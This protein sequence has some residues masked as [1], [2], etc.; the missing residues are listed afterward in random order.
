LSADLLDDTVG[1]AKANDTR[2]MHDILPENIDLDTLQLFTKATVQTVVVKI[3][4]RQDWQIASVASRTS[5]VPPPESVSKVTYT[6]TNPFD[7]SGAVRMERSKVSYGEAPAFETKKEIASSNAIVENKG[8][9]FLV[10]NDA[11]TKKAKVDSAEFPVH[12]NVFAA[13]VGCPCLFLAVSAVR[14]VHAQRR[15]IT[16]VFSWRS[17]STA[18]RGKAKQESFAKAFSHGVLRFSLTSCGL[19]V[20]G[21]CI[22]S[23]ALATVVGPAQQMHFLLP[24]FLPAHAQLCCTTAFRSV[25]LSIACIPSLLCVLL[26]SPRYGIPVDHFN[27]LSGHSFRHNP[28]MAD[29]SH[30]TPSEKL[31]LAGWKDKTL[32]TAL[33]SNIEARVARPTFYTQT[34][35]LAQARAKAEL[36]QACAV[37]AKES[38]AKLSK[39]PLTLDQ[40]AS[41]WSLKKAAIRAF[42]DFCT[43]TECSS[44]AVSPTGNQPLEDAKFTSVPFDERAWGVGFLTSTRQTLILALRSRRAAPRLTSSLRVS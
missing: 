16:A 20:L 32:D 29:P 5:L 3:S 38:R 26:S 2:I 43:A 41:F 23:S 1:I 21:V 31:S 10:N 7:S 12:E 17:P 28:S 30:F 13:A 34:S 24:V 42:K 18:Y 25:A 40:R 4:A 14:A 8:P 36:V 9:V 6:R 11:Y 22:R 19:V 44:R 33:L 15:L 35:P 39:A 37:V 27:D